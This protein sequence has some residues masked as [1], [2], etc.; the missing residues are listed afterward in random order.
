MAFDRSQAEAILERALALDADEPAATI[1]VDAL[2]RLGDELGISPA[3]L[4]EAMEQV[5]GDRSS[6]PLNVSARATVRAS[7]A[8]T[9]AG[10]ASFMRLRG[11]DTDGSNV[12]RQGSGW[13]PDLFRFRAVT[14]VSFSLSPTGDE[15]RVHL[16]A[17]LDGVWRAH[18]L[19]AILGALF[20][21]VAWL[22]GPDL[23]GMVA[24][25]TGAAAW[26]ALCVWA[27]LYRR[28]VVRRRLADALRDVSGPRYRRNPW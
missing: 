6:G 4:A 1:D 21:V 11:L 2:Q 8:E 7:R 28:E 15:T 10:F 23:T 5:P 14:P 18:L 22:T 9:Q 17:R 26:I 3:S 20:A 24:A 27:Y 13:W 25:L 12:W 19:A 16:T